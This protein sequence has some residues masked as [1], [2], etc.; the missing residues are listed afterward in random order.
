MQIKIGAQW[1]SAIKIAARDGE[2]GPPG[3]PGDDADVTFTKV[4]AVLGY[5]YKTV[6]GD[7]PTKVTGSYIYS[8]NVLG[9]TFLGS[10]FYAGEGSGYSRMD[11]EGF[12]I[13][14]QDGA[15]KLGIGYKT[16]TDAKDVTTTYP[17]ITLGVGAG[18]A[19]EQEGLIYKLGNGLWI[20]DA[21]VLILGGNYPGGKK[22]VEDI[23]DTIPY[24]TGIFV[25][26]T[27]NAIYQYINGVP[28]I[29]GSGGS[30]GGTAIAVFG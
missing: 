4:N 5:I 24:A 30:G 9:G 19:S 25:D 8:P 11:E 29:I 18:N 14:D 3:E 26:V 15:N 13:Y 17:H 22:Y 20:G 10:E 6:E 16:Y 12:N 27:N 21:S 28:S 1:S 23:S 2:I 7:V